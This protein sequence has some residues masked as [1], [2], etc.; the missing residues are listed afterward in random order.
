MIFHPNRSSLM[1]AARLRLTKA[2]KILQRGKF[3]QAEDEIT[4][5]LYI[6]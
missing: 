2:K 6:F 4:V 5:A 3:K 1:N